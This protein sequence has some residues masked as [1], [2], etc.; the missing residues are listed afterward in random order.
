MGLS[1]AWWDAS[2]ATCYTKDIN[3]FPQIWAGLSLLTL[4]SS[5]DGDLDGQ[6]KF[7]VSRGRAGDITLFSESS[8]AWSTVAEE[9]SHTL[10]PVSS[11]ERK[12][13]PKSPGIKIH[14]QLAIW[15]MNFWI[16]EE[17]FLHNKRCLQKSPFFYKV[18][19]LS[20]RGNVNTYLRAAQ[21]EKLFKSQLFCR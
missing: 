11:D 18:R 8:W 16:F 14:S 17:P 15:C 19:F 2:C 9:T 5:L 20:K 6:L 4:P 13:F 21:N 3:S 12:A 1:S 10:F 7:H